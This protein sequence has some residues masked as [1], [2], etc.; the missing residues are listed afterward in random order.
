M[1]LVKRVTQRDKVDFI[2]QKFKVGE[3][4]NQM[5]QLMTKV[6]EKEITPSTVNAA[7]NCV[8]RINE[9]IDTAIR[10]AKF[11]DER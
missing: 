9:T 1:E 2:D 7:C 3:A 8:S 10:A 6:T 11:L 4:I 5:H